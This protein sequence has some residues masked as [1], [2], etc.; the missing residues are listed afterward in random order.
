[1]SFPGG[2]DADPDLSGGAGGEYEAG[3]PGIQ[4]GAGCEPEAC[5]GGVASGNAS[6]RKRNDR[7]L[8]RFGR[9]LRVTGLG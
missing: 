9:D 4:E 7:D 2:A 8:A 3:W 6:G 1:M 5:V